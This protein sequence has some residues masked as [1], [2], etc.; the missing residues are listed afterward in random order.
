MREGHAT[1]CGTESPD[2][3]RRATRIS[4]VARQCWRVM[5][6]FGGKLAGQLVFKWNSNRGTGYSRRFTKAMAAPCRSPETVG[7]AARHILL[8]PGDVFLRRWNWKAALLSS[9]FR[10]VAFAV[11]M[12]RL[13]PHDALRAICIEASLCIAIGGFW[14]SLLQAMRGAR[15]VW[16]ASL[17]AAVILPAAFHCAEY[18]VLRAGNVVHVKTGVVVSVIVTIGSL[19]INFGLMRRGLLITGEHSG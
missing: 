8:H 19:L 10:S 18:G 3:L 15:P 2:L 11:P 6:G 12:T 5:S 16:L 9:V 1:S 7:A 4:R 13:A 17:W 14:G